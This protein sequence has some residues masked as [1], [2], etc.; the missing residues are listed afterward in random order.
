MGVPG[1][2]NGFNSERK[3]SK[4]KKSYNIRITGL[5]AGRKGRWGTKFGVGKKPEQELTVRD[6]HLF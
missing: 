5:N 6:P 1:K 4:E 3:G 2:R